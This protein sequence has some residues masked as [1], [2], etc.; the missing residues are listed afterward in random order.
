[1][2]SRQLAVITG[3]C[4]CTNNGEERALKS[5]WVKETVVFKWFWGDVV[6]MK[7]CL[8]TTP[9]YYVPEHEAKR[10]AVMME[11]GVICHLK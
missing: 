8:P 11:M 3:T 2:R 6:G 9:C 7:G 1:M 4:D 5:H 10:V